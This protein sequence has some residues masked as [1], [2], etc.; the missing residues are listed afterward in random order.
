M[1]F[2]KMFVT[3]FF[4]VVLVISVSIQPHKASDST[5]KYVPV[6]VTCLSIVC[7]STYTSRECEGYC[8]SKGYNNGEC[9]PLDLVKPVAPEHC[10]C[11]YVKR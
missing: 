8:I 10:C 4:V 1:S 5:K 11:Y 6:G 2:T 3:Y 7:T 9:R